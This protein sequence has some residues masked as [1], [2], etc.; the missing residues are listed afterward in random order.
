MANQEASFTENICLSLSYFNLAMYIKF[1]F[2]FHCVRTYT[3][4][5]TIFLNIV[6]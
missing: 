1:N 3:I 6:K 5:E 2:D 4:E